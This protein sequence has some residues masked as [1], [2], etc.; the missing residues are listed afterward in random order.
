MIS[1]II[2]LKYNE[3][4]TYLG[5]TRPYLNA[6]IAIDSLIEQDII[7]EIIVCNSFSQNDLQ[8]QYLKNHYQ[9]KIRIIE[10]KSTI[11]NISWCI[12]VGIKHSS[13][14]YFMRHD[15]DCILPPDFNQSIQSH[16]SLLE[17]NHVL[18]STM[19]DVT[20]EYDWT[21]FKYSIENYNILLQLSDYQFSPSQI[22]CNKQIL[23]DLHGYDENYKEWGYQDRD[24]VHRIKLK[25]HKIHY[26]IMEII[27]QPHINKHILMAQNKDSQ[28]QYSQNSQ[29]F[30]SKSFK[31]LV[32]NSKWGD[33]SE[34]ASDVNFQQL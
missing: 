6:C 23:K 13:E 30:K 27:H 8:I 2:P 20:V 19:M 16:I 3:S 33:L 4:R 32:N 28:N 9:D 34:P 11:F 24:I 21:S 18:H 31:K 12:N 7:G 14:P 17:N 22:V 26:G 10:L 1:A 15:I 5:I 29:Y 25:G